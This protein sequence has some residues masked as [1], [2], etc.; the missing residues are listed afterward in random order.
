MAA[1]EVDNIGL[2]RIQID[3]QSDGMGNQVVQPTLVTNSGAFAS[4]SYEAP[5]GYLHAVMSEGGVDQYECFIG[6]S[7]E[8]APN[9]PGPGALKNIRPI[10]IHLS[11]TDKA[12]I[13]GID[14]VQGLVNQLLPY[15]TF[16]V[17]L[18]VQKTPNFLPRIPVG[19]PAPPP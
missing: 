7:L 17:V 1:S 2:C 14:G 12:V 16:W 13:L 18:S 6:M 4:A 19:T 11:D 3:V 9:N 5:T 15:D 10:V 8:V